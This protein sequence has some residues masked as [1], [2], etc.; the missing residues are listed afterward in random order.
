M[1]MKTDA[2]LIPEDDWGLHML[3]TDR[4]TFLLSLV[5]HIYGSVS[6]KETL[7]V[8]HSSNSSEIFPPLGTSLSSVSSLQTGMSAPHSSSRYCGGISGLILF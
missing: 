1:V 8:S 6:K 2:S 5:H 3:C 4:G 7:A